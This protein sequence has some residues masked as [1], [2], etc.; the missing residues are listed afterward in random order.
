M[1]KNDTETPVTPQPMIALSAEMLQT[2]LEQIAKNNLDM[3]KSFVEEQRK[4]TEAEVEKRRREKEYWRQ[5]EQEHKDRKHYVQEILCTH[6]HPANQKSHF[7]KME[8]T[9]P[10]NGWMMVCSRCQKKL[11]NY[12]EE[13]GKLLQNPEEF[14]RWFRVPS[15]TES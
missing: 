7:F 13:T 4:P 10:Q 2:M 1:A 5:L 3:V 11:V 9:Y 14:N 12:D 6:I 15:Q 8:V